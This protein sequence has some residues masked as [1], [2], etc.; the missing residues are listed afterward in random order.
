MKRKIIPYNPKLKELA[1]KLRS[2]STLGEVLLWKELNNKKMYGYDFHRQKPLLNYIVDLYCYE[3]NL[4][5]EVDGQYHTHEE[6]YKLDLLREKELEKYNLTVMR[7]T[8]QEVRK[9]IV[10]VLRTIETYILKFE[11]SEE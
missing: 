6:T 9:D 2:D 1:R 11:A 4:V 3:L 5:I 10:N 7:F 8:E